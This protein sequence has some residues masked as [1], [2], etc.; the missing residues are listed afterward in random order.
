M[1]AWQIASWVI[2]TLGIGGTI[3]AFILYPA[4]VTPILN[5]IGKLFAW[6]FSYRLGCAIAAAIVAAF[7]AMY[8]Q[9]SRD[10]ADF[11]KRTAEFEAAQDARDK[12]IAA[13]TREEV[14]TEIA[15]Q[16]ALNTATDQEVKE[17]HD[18]LPPIPHTGNPFRVGAAAGKLRTIA[19]QVERGSRPSA[20]GVPKAQSQGRR[21]IH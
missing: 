15:N 2:G 4:I 9:Q 3:V 17:F 10:N 21:P 20:A 16:T 14:W 18:A 1:S 7:L 11:A 8:W 12:R 6:V 13:E 19:G 5:G